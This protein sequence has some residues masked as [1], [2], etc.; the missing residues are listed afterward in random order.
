[1]ISESLYKEPVL[2]ITKE[3]F[4]ENF[5][6][7]VSI[8]KN[9]P[10][11]MKLRDCTQI[12]FNNNNINDKVH[13]RQTHTLRVA[14]ISKLIAEKF[15]LSEFE[16]KLAELIGL[17]HDLGHTALG[18]TGESRVERV[19]EFYNLPKEEFA[20]YYMKKYDKANI[21]EMPD[22]NTMV[23][24]YFEHHAH[25]TRILRKILKDN[26]VE[27]TDDILDILEM[28]VLLH[29]ESRSDK[30]KIDR[31][32]YTIPR[33]ADK[34]YAFTDIYDII[35][36]E[37]NVPR[38]IFEQIIKDDKIKIYLLKQGIFIDSEDAKKSKEELKAFI[39]KY[40]PDLADSEIQKIID[41]AT[42]LSSEEITKVNTILDGFESRP[43]ET[44]EVCIDDYITGISLD[45]NEQDNS[46]SINKKHEMK[47]IMR[48]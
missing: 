12:I 36:S 9:S 37:N 10:E 18:H 8:I 11:F 20:M 14:E 28:G 13:N 3:N 1:M 34:S 26:N 30:V 19:L 16:Q 35:C 15:G 17:C 22:R 40:E 32:L 21:E 45:Y 47:R 48:V 38:D 7:L 27:I 24:H 44:L 31:A 29:S 2:K 4:L 23:E 43:K 41:N 42:L 39:K 46:Y 33:T 6:E 5:D 25:S